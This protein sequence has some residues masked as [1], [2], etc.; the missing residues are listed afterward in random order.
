[1]SKAVLIMDMP[2]SCQ[3]CRL[4]RKTPCNDWDRVCCP[5]YIYIWILNQL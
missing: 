4:S 5:A 3:R 2:E 1:M